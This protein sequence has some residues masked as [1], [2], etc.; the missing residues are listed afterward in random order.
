MNVARMLGQTVGDSLERSMDDSQSTGTKARL[1]GLC[2]VSDKVV[3]AS[4]ADGTVVRT[5]DGGTHWT[6]GVVPGAADLD[7]RDVHAFDDRKAFLL[8]I[9]AGEKS[10]IYQTIDG[11]ASWTIRFH[12]RDPKVFLDAL[13]FWDAD[14]GIALGD[15]V[16]GQI[17]DPHDGKWRHLM[18]QAS[19]GADARSPCRR[20]CI[21]RQRH[22]PGRSRKSK[23]V[24]RNRRG[25][26]CPRVSLDGRRS[27]VDG[28][29]D[30]HPGRQ[31]LVGHFLAGVSDR[32]GRHR[33]RR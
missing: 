9:G 4:G 18:E 21:R 1:R 15:P 20:R 19:R 32:V 30:A 17:H 10:R 8:S 29:P 11:G 33:R 6:A 23:R 5:V 3:W 2:V 31:R 16:D 14:H 26:C 12:N 25:R 7:F 13:E 27:D 24:V 22:L 28:P